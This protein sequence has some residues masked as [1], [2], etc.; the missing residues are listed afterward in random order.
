[1]SSSIQNKRIKT[2]GVSMNA[3]K[4]YISVFLISG[5]IGLVLSPASFADNLGLAVVNQNTGEVVGVIVAD[6]LDPFNSGGIL[7][8]EY[9]GCTNCQLVP[10]STRNEN[11]NVTGY[12]S[13]NNASVIYDFVDN[14]FTI[15]ESNIIKTSINEVATEV[16][17]ERITISSKIGQRVFKFGFQ[18]VSNTNGQFQLTEVAPKQLTPVE[19]QA[20]KEVV[21]CVVG[22]AYGL[23]NGNCD[24][25]SNFNQQSYQEAVESIAFSERKTVEEVQEEALDKNLQIIVS[26]IDLVIKQ[27]SKWIK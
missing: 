8:G 2:K 20:T 6:S 26:N 25:D 19:I 21:T 18:D 11:E 27:L 17:S 16:S 10:Q 9:M 1:M 24:I 22:Q 4:K 5:F 14:S 15:T 12:R 7:P 3:F 23:K 13:D